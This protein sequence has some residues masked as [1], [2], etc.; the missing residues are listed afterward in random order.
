ML[1]P[2]AAK[3]LEFKRVILYKFGEACDGGVWKY[4]NMSHQERNGSGPTLEVEY[5]F[6]KLYVAASRAIERLFVVDSAT[7]DAQL[8][9]Y[10]SNTNDYEKLIAD[11]KEWNSQVRPLTIGTAESAQELQEDDPESIAK[12]FEE[13]GLN[14]GSANP[15]RRAK[16]YYRRLNNSRKAEICEAW[17]LK[18]EEQ[19]HAAGHSF[20]KLGEIDEAF[21]CFWQ[22]LCWSELVAW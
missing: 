4:L 12:E 18:F 1:S 2:I 20:G 6:N 19:W 9:I 8:W 14:A 22:G 7:G 13:E 21:D 11:R 10:A 16:G 15:I 17:A 3:G 5:F